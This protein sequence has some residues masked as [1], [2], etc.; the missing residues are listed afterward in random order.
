MS[1]RYVLGVVPPLFLS[2]S[3]SAL[4]LFWFFVPPIQILVISTYQNPLSSVLATFS[5]F[6]EFCRLNPNSA[7]AILQFLDQ[8]SIFSMIIPHLL[9]SLVVYAGST[10]GVCM[11]SNKWKDEHSSFISFISAFLS[12]NAFRLNIV[13]IAP[14]LIDFKVLCS[15]SYS[16]WVLLRLFLVSRILFSTVE[17]Y[18]WHSYSWHPGILTMPRWSMAGSLAVGLMA[19]LKGFFN[20]LICWSL[21]TGCIS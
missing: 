4:N 12:T 16:F 6:I 8:R 13:P 7:I 5:R 2:D 15:I 9:V 17:V 1:Y 10:G 20:E 18:Q 19:F 11:M 3:S 14:V 21:F